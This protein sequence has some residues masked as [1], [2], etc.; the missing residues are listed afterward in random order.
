MTLS[1]GVQQVRGEEEKAS[2]EWVKN[3]QAQVELKADKAE[4]E[5]V[6]KEANG[7]AEEMHVFVVVGGMLTSFVSL[8]GNRL[9]DAWLGRKQQPVKGRRG[10][11]RLRPA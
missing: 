8:F 7:T 5:T 9:L 11:S 1:G 3:I 4:L 2:K 6:K 10:S